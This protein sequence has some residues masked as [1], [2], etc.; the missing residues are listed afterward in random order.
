MKIWG[1]VPKVSGVYGKH[2]GLDK[3]E[4]TAPVKNKKD[5]ISISTQGKDYQA[6]VKAV[7]ETPDI[8]QEKINDLLKKYE[9]GNYNVNGKEVADNIIKSIIDRKI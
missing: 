4:R 2:K 1:D 5:I 7:K 6:A 3:V 8:R 9:S